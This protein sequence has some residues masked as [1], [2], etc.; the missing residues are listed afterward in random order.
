MTDKTKELMSEL[1][2]LAE[3]DHMYGCS[4]N[5]CGTERGRTCK[6][7]A[8]VEQIEALRERSVSA[9]RIILSGD[10]GGG[11]RELEIGVRKTD[12]VTE[13]IGRMGYEQCGWSFREHAEIFTK[14]GTALGIPVLDETR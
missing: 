2:G 13:Q 4:P 9:P 8:I 6:T 7:G 5:V 1:A 12:G 3:L 11:R 10:T 14:L